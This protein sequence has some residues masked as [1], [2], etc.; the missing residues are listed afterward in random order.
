MEKVLW[1]ERKYIEYP[2][3]WVEIREEIKRRD[4]CKCKKCGEQEYLV[5][6]HVLPLSQGRFF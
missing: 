4:G 5:V 1:D 6:H 3:N 2:E